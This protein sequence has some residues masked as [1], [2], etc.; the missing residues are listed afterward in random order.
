MYIP[1]LNAFGIKR[2]FGLSHCVIALSHWAERQLR[3]CPGLWAYGSNAKCVIALG[4][5]LT[6]VTLNVS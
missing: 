5:G 4:F 1:G 3:H 2:Q 6:A